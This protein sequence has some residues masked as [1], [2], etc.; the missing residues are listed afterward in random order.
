[1]DHLTSTPNFTLQHLRFLII[2][3]ADR[4]LGQ[5][6]QNWL[7]EV[8]AHTRAPTT[9]A[10]P[11]QATPGDAV[12]GAWMKASGLPVQEWEGSEQDGLDGNVSYC[13]ARTDMQC[14]KLLF[15]ATLTRDPSKIAS[16]HLRHPRY[17]IV[18]A[19]AAGATPAAF[20][21][22]FALPAGLKAS[23]SDFGFLTGRK[24]WSSWHR[25][26]NL[27]SYCICFIP[28]SMLCLPRCVSRNLSN[29]QQGSSSSSTTLKMPSS[30]A[31]EATPASA[32]LQRATRASSRRGKGRDC[33]KDS[34]R[35][36]STCKSLNYTSIG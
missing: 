11:A 35:V 24:K 10:E 17:F 22:Q 36:Q 4:L 19:N 2:D 28:S 3:E 31:G 18:Q 21:E 27:W 12:A 7:P 1:M 6:F 25:S 20:G 9:Q 5:S 8:L 30:L 13:S 32:L 16:L 34:Q 23:H 26:S 33:S 14:Q 29:R 15:S